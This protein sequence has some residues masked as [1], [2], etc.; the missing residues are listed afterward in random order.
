MT[1]ESDLVASY[2]ILAELYYD[3]TCNKVS[4]PLCFISIHVKPLLVKYWIQYNSVI[5]SRWTTLCHL[6]NRMTSFEP[7][8]I[9]DDHYW[10]VDK[11]T[12][13]AIT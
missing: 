5:H 13:I 2:A 1:I 3:K 9:L 12:N 10:Y 6:K 4:Y 11:L 7:W 8:L